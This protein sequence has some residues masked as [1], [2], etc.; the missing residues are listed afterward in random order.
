MHDGEFAIRQGRWKNGIPGIGTNTANVE[1]KG[2]KKKRAERHERVVP[3]DGVS[4]PMRWF[5]NRDAWCVRFLSG[6]SQKW[7]LKY[8]KV[9]GI[10]RGE[11]SR[12]THA[13]YQEHHTPEPCIVDAVVS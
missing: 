4:S 5:G 8:F 3:P 10:G 6:E 2:I 9:D 11:A 12:E 7:K 1:M 13:F